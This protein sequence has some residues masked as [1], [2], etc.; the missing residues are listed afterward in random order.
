M[1]ESHMAPSAAPRQSSYAHLERYKGKAVVVTIV[2]LVVTLVL[3]LLY[4]SKASEAS[5]ILND[6]TSYTYSTEYTTSD[7]QDAT[8]LAGVLG[9][10][11]A[12]SAG[13]GA[14]AVACWVAVNLLIAYRKDAAGEPLG[15]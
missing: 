11:T 1:A 3:G 14:C 7:Y 8:A 10:C 13:V 12:I 15:D 9:W 5:N 6:I 4:L 2:A